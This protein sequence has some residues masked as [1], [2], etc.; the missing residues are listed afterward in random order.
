MLPCTKVHGFLEFFIQNQQ[1][2]AKWNFVVQKILLF[3]R[4]SRK[5]RQLQS[6]RNSQIRISDSHQESERVKILETIVCHI[7]VEQKHFSN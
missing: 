1:N 4:F 2:S 5:Q 6:F 3:S 7:N